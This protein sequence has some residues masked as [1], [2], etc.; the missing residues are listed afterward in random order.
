MNKIQIAIPVSVMFSAYEDRIK[1]YIAYLRK[2]YLEE[3]SLLM[4]VTDEIK[5]ELPV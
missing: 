2:M 5:E 4:K 1:E 3:E